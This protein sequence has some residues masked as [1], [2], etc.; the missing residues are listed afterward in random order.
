MVH[1]IKGFREVKNYQVILYARVEMVG[2][3]VCKED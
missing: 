2:Y 3:L 1:F